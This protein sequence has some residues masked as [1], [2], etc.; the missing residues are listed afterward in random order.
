MR[1]SP[2]LQ[3]RS[4]LPSFRSKEQLIPNLTTLKP[5]FIFTAG[6]SRVATASSEDYLND[7]YLPL[8]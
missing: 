6:G 8:G 4:S 1:V 3:A 5:L 7:V 2:N